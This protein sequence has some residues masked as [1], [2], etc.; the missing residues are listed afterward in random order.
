[1]FTDFNKSSNLRFISYTFLNS[2]SSLRPTFLFIPNSHSISYTY[3]IFFS[4]VISQL[5]DYAKDNTNMAGIM[6]ESSIDNIKR[7]R[8]TPSNTNVSKKNVH[9]YL[10]VFSRNFALFRCF[11]KP[12]F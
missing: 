5:F 4:S 3:L 8:P 1:M 2:F 6:V 9:V 10:Y 11:E 12:L 7:S